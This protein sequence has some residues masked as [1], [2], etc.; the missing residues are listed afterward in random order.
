MTKIQFSE[1]INSIGDV[2]LYTGIP[3]FEMLERLSL[4]HGDIWHSSFEQ[5]YKN[6]FPEI[7]YQTAVFFWYGMD[8]DNLDECVSWRLNPKHFAIRKNV[9]DDLTGFDEEFKTLD[10]QGFDFAYNALRNQGAIPLYVKGLYEVVIDNK[11]EISTHDRYLFFIKNYGFAQSFYM[12]LRKGIWRIKEWHGLIKA[13][14]RGFKRSKTEI[15]R[16]RELNKIEGTPRVSYIIPTMLRQDYTLQLLKDLENQ[17]YQVHQVIVVDATPEEKRDASLYKSA[18]FPFEVIFKWQT[19]KGSCRARNEAIDLC[20]G[21]Y[22]VFG[23]DDIRI[24]PDFIENHIRLLQTY[25]ASACN[26]LDIM[27]DN[28][29]QTL[30]DLEIKLNEISKDRLKIGASQSFSN[31]NSCVKTEHVKNL[32]GNDINYDGGYGEDSDFGISL[33]KIGVTVLHNPFS[34]NL[35]L[36]PPQGGYRFWGK[37]AKLIGKKRKKQP[38][39]LD[40]PV[41]FIRP[42]PSPTIMY[43]LYKQFN[44]SQRKAYFD[45]YF[46]RYLFKGNKLL[47]P[48]RILRLPYKFMQYRRSE[49]YAKRLL[50]LGKRTK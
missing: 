45:K 41:K 17:T 49:Y 15:T 12:T 42:V 44:K 28:S 9:W 11:I 16:A 47:I 35:H 33:T 25:K 4:G 39:E 46:L 27:A 18:E 24:K 23:D 48:L 13:K 1:Y 10:M 30:E 5:G 31:A 6:A 26:G 7:I 32:I 36:R 21:D 38:W 29:K 20:T 2:I 34:V 22:I 37:Q 14:N 40:K 19:T 43:Q 8:F 50:A 3:D